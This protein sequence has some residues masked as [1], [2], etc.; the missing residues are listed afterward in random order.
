MRERKAKKGF[1]SGESHLVVH[2][3]KDILLKSVTFY[4][5]TFCIKGRPL[6]SFVTEY[7][8]INNKAYSEVSYFI[9]SNENLARLF[10]NYLIK[11]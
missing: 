2:S 10:D 5:N 11:F 1:K 4:A 7:S 3:P 6:L 8:G 9:K